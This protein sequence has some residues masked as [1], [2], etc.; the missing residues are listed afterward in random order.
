MILKIILF[1][2]GSCF[3]EARDFFTSKG[4]L[5]AIVFYAIGGFLLVNVVLAFCLCCHPEKKQKQGFYKRM[6]Y[7]D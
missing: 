6:D 4:R 1:R 7:Y 5:L 3:E 2:N